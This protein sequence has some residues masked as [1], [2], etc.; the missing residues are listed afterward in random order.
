MA[1]V[2]RADL[3]RLGYRAKPLKNQLLLAAD[4]DE[5]MHKEGIGLDCLTAERV[6]DFVRQRVAGGARVLYSVRAL[7]PL[8]RFLR[9]QG[10]VP[11][12][13]PIRLEGPFETLL[14]SFG[15]YL[16]EERGL[17]AFTQERYV[18]W[19][20]K[21]LTVSLSDGRVGIETLRASDVH[22]FV[23]SSCRDLSA[24][25]AK[26]MVSALRA[27]LRYLYVSGSTELELWGATPGVPG[28]TM[29]HLPMGLPADQVAR[30]LHAC[31]GTSATDLRD[32][33]VIRLVARLGLRA[34]EVA[35]LNLNDVDWRHS[36]FVVRGKGRRSERLPLSADVGEVMVDYLRHGRPPSPERAL[37]L[38]VRVP[39]GRLEASA[40][41]AIV[42]RAATRIGLGKIG[43]HR[44]R[45]SAATGMLARGASLSEVGQ[46]LRHDSAASTAIYAKVDRLT[47]R[48]LARPWPGGAA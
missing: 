4:V 5:W 31:D 46:V 6:E 44:L 48:E 17:A 12:A 37:F 42:A 34:G 21:F 7:D 3:V 41:G 28:F 9:K 35:A 26:Q 14:A 18:Q 23:V 1:E 10:A 11:E 25:A 16:A 20:R 15:L 29:R 27:L 40:V 24:S 19:S 47:L 33:A 2:F 39:G 45:H 36:E 30:L 32:R 8:L 43:P 13:A 38:S 22:R